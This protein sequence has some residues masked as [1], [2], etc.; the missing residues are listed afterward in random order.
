MGKITR[1]GV[2]KKSRTLPALSY[3][4]PT[5]L[6]RK[7]PP[8]HAEPPT[9]RHSFPRLRKAHALLSA[10]FN[11]EYTDGRCVLA[12]R[13]GQVMRLCTIACNTNNVTAESLERLS[14]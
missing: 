3:D 1:N 7:L 4:R 14:R 12:I 5:I 10:T 11:S 13:S 9:E 2:Y 8:L 6:G